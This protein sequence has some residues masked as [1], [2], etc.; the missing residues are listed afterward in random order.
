MKKVYE[1][2]EDAGHRYMESKAEFPSAYTN[3]L[4]LFSRF[5]YLYGENLI[6]DNKN[7]FFEISPQKT[8]GI[9]GKI[10]LILSLDSNYSESYLM[11]INYW[12]KNST[13]S[14]ITI[15]SDFCR[16]KNE[17]R[18]IVLIKEHNIYELPLEELKQIEEWCSDSFK[19]LFL[20][21]IKKI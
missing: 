11:T 19:K 15:K 16:E 14:P 18:Q 12:D 20:E 9:K 8:K 17:L 1:I 2:F 5:Y 6:G 13:K 21:E 4:Y 7:L 10:A 3:I